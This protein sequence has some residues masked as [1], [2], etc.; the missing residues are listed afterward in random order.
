MPRNDAKTDM[1][2]D[3]YIELLKENVEQ[4]T[5]KKLQGPK[6]FHNLSENIF[7]RLKIMISPTTLKR[8]W[9]YLNEGGAPRLSTLSILSQFI[10]YRDWKDFCENHANNN[11]Q[12][13]LIMSRKLSTYSLKKGDRILITW[14]PDRMCFIEYTGDISFIVLDSKN[15]KI[16]K[17]DTF[18]CSI[19]IEGEPLYADNLKHGIYQ[20]ISYVAGKK[21]GIRFELIS[22][23]QQ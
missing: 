12:S 9:G 13:N 5:G 11:A 22:N 18:E 1:D 16:Q 7:G 6:D 17:S 15:S 3:R 8:L 23:T 20:G 21:N 10:G 2:N 4:I 19:F 14:L